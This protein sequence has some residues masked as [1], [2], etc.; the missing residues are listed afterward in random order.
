M[1]R[2]EEET[3][4]GYRELTQAHNPD[5]SA[6][7]GIQNFFIDTTELSPDETFDLTKRRLD[8]FLKKLVKNSESIS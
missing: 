3:R 1:R 6:F 5:L 8:D 2:Q 7:E 4:R